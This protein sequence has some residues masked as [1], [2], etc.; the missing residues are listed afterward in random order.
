[1]TKPQLSVCGTEQAPYVYFFLPL[2]HLGCF[3]YSCMWATPHCGIYCSFISFKSLQ[4]HQHEWNKVSITEICEIWDLIFKNHLWYSHQQSRSLASTRHWWNRFETHRPPTWEA[5]PGW[6]C[7]WRPC[8]HTPTWSWWSFA[9][10]YI[11]LQ[12]PTGENMVLNV[13]V[14]NSFH[15]ISWG[16]KWTKKQAFSSQGQGGPSHCPCFTVICTGEEHL[17]IAASWKG[18]NRFKIWIISWRCATE[19]QMFLS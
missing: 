4:F 19:G 1:M 8:L 13:I 12:R 5:S 11:C 14:K 6:K 17:G 2:L 9:A 10:R 3:L 16:K 7:K 18:S 15:F